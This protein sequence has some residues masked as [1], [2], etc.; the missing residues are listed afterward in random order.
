MYFYHSYYKGKE[1][2]SWY[3]KNEYKKGA[4]IYVSIMGWIVFPQIR[5]VKS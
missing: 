3:L 2:F 1:Y 4:L 5:M